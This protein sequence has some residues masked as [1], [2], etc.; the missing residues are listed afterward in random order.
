MDFSDIIKY[1]LVPCTMIIVG[2]LFKLHAEISH[3]LKTLESTC[4]CDTDV[5]TL[6]ADKSEVLV[7]ADKEQ[8]AR[9]DRL[10]IYITR[11]DYK[12]DKI[13]DTL[14]LNKPDTKE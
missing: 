10:E 1:I 7:L 8:Q 3:R 2:Y 9:L 11:I 14:L 4:L 5:R 6:I 13:I 12:L